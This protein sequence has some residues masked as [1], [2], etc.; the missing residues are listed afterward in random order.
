M[1][2]TDEEWKGEKRGE[3]L[4]IIELS[5]PLREINGEAVC[6]AHYY[7]IFVQIDFSVLSLRLISF[8][9]AV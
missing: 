4:P 8:L 7:P 9:A 5:P 1:R 2:R 3:G 6:Y